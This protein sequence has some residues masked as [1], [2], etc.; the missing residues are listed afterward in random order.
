MWA[1][2]V[3]ISDHCFLYPR[4]EKVRVNW[5][6][7]VRLFVLPSIPSVCPL[8]AEFFRQRFLNNR[9]SEMVIFAMQVHDDLL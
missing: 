3:F 1:L 5:F 7:S 2:I 9:A 4:C 6:T 8:F